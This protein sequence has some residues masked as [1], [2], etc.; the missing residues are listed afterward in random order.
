MMRTIF[1][2]VHERPFPRVD[3]RLSY[4]GYVLLGKT[5]CIVQFF[6]EHS[7]LRGTSPCSTLSYN[8]SK[9]LSKS[10]PAKMLSSMN[11]CSYQTKNCPRCLLSYRLDE[12]PSSMD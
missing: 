4:I 9:M 6:R 8:V 11:W 2:K 1:E 3:A 5:A 12:T 7:V 10:R